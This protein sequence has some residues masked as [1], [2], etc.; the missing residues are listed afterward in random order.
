MAA[1]R[2]RFNKDTLSYTIVR[3]G[4]R[5]YLGVGVKYLLAGLALAVL[6]YV[7]VSLFGYTPSERRLAHE[8]EELEKAVRELSGRYDQVS[9][10]LSDLENR[11]RNIYRIIFESEPEAL[12]SEQAEQAVT[13]LYQRLQEEGVESLMRGSTRALRRLDTLSAQQSLRFDTVM[14]LVKKH[15]ASLRYIPSIQPV[16][17]GRLGSMVGAFGRRIHPF[18]KSLR[19]HSGVDYAMPVGSAVYATADG[20][21]ESVKKSQRGYGNMIRLQHGEDYSTVYAHLSEVKVR[22]GASVKRGDVIG[23]VGNT[24]MS[25][26]PHLHY[27]VHFKG[28]AVDPI[29][30]FFGELSPT[31]IEQ[32]VRHASQSGQTLD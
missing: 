29:N 14:A 16:D 3:R 22:R 25:L 20:R 1:K 12:E 5:W 2:Y 23:L 4:W 18:Y 13:D 27:E 8:R 10:V 9:A 17:N 19:M 24:G 28:K 11:D 31:Q 6:V 30:F 15:G 21:V 7:V 26:A 32:L